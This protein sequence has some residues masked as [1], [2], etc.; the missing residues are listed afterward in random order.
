MSEPPSM[1]L[2]FTEGWPT[3][4]AIPT[5]TLKHT[6]D[7]TCISKT[8]AS[9]GSARVGLRVISL[10]PVCKKKTLWPPE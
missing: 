8:A 9:M 10:P 2:T 7:W 1:T 4:S 5:L 3:V 6:Q